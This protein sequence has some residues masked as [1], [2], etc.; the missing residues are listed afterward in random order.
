MIP[1][2]KMPLKSLSECYFYHL[3]YWSMCM[4][5]TRKRFSA[6]VWAHWLLSVFFFFAFGSQ[7]FF[8]RL[9]SA[10]L[11]FGGGAYMSRRDGRR[12]NKR[13]HTWSSMESMHPRANRLNNLDSA[14][15][16]LVGVFL[17]SN[18][19]QDIVDLGL[20]TRVKQE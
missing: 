4:G 10:Q 5:S 20:C 12:R 1:W 14:R 17:W 9:H 7:F 16:K 11:N 13:S 6:P 19:D 2:L 15:K 3:E 18:W 8:S